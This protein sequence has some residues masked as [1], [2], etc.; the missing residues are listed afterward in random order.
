[1]PHAT[2]RA[3]T[4]IG[5]AALLG[6]VST[7]AIAADDEASSAGN[8]PCLVPYDEGADVDVIKGLIA[9]TLDLE[10][11]EAFVWDMSTVRVLWYDLSPADCQELQ[12]SP[13]EGIQ[14]ATIAAEVAADPDPFGT[15][16]PYWPFTPG[17][18]GIAGESFSGGQVEPTGYQRVGAEP[19]DY[20]DVDVA[21]VDTGVDQFHD[22]LNVVGG[23]DCTDP[24]HGDDNW[25]HD[26]Y[27][28]GTHVAGI[29]AA[30][31]NDRGV[32][33]NAAGARIWS[34]KV[35]GEDGSGSFASV[36]CGIDWV[37]GQANTI[38]LANLSLGGQIPPTPLWGAD[39]VHN[40]FGI[41]HDLGVTIVVSGGNDGIDSINSSPA[42]YSES[43][44]T[45]SALTDYDGRAGGLAPAP[46]EIP[47]EYR[48]DYRALFSNFGS[49][50][51]FIAPGVDILSTLPLNTYGRASGT[52]MAAPEVT[53]TLAAFIAQ[54]GQAS[55]ATAVDV[56]KA[57]SS[58]VWDADNTW[59]GDIGVDHEPLVRFGAPCDLELPEE[60]S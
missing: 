43:V 45:V 56:V 51:D 37:A 44:V 52:S 34:V 30:L 53:G 5:A 17:P 12:D 8:E 47:A 10:A 22:D 58:D 1:M 20:A 35:L 28:H 15:G 13:I 41:A 23:F 36:L 27:G 29:I 11:D 2:R 32:V 25:G 46:N 24:Q 14:G 49:V 3:V 18:D 38:E 59:Q 19:G 40:G 16:T 50:I 39:P 26:G 6:L 54:C 33:G 57:W 21:V 7:P 60:A 55:R 4:V 31:D 42:N 48:D 9:A